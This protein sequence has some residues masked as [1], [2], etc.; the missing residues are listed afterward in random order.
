ME[1]ADRYE[2]RPEVSKQEVYER[3]ANPVVPDK[4]L[5]PLFLTIRSIL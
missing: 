5:R 1:G 2:P 4:V 3:K